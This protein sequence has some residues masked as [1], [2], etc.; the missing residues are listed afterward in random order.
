VGINALIYYSPTLFQ[1]MGLEYDMQLIMSGVLNC[2]QLVGV[3]SSLWT[4]D[5]IGRRPLLLWGSAVMFISHLII[6]VLVGKYS[7]DWPSYRPEG[8]ASVAMLLV[9]M[10]GFG[11]SWVSHYQSKCCQQRILIHVN[12]VLS[13]GQCHP[14]SSPP[15]SVPRVSRKSCFNI[16]FSSNDPLTYTPRLST[17]CNW[18]FNFII[19]LITPPLIESTGFGAYVFFAVFCLLSLFWVYF[20]VPETAG[21]TL[22]EMDHVFGDDS[23]T[24]EEARRE[25][26]EMAI[27]ARMGGN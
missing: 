27:A 8:W 20:F 3:A 14:K 2:V 17:S 10:L 18:L 21:K 7:H 24:G 19:G 15:A 12:R 23:S 11:A 25:R 1:T 22:E 4:M 9:F 6:S 5:R 13:H 26:I 16:L